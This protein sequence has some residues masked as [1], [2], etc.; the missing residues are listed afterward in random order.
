MVAGGGGAVKAGKACKR[1]VG[2]A[3][4]GQG[5][6]IGFGCHVGQAWAPLWPLIIPEV[7][8]NGYMKAPGKTPVL[9][10]SF[11]IELRVCLLLMLLG[12]E[13][14]LHTEIN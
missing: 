2:R 12:G 5:P 6:C 8:G 13:K 11:Q 4:Y 14:Q 9:R 10:I 3:R 7:L 1:R